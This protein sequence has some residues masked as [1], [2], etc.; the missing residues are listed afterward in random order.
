VPDDVVWKG[1]K[2]ICD[3]LGLKEDETEIYDYK[4]EEIE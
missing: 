3:Y 4:G 2:A 1:K